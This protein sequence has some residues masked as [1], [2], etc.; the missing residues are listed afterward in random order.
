M[1]NGSFA[2][3]LQ[4]I[5]RDGNLTGADLA[6]WFDRPDPTVRGWISGDHELS[7]PPLD[8]AFVLA[9]LDKLERLLKQNKGLPVPRMAP[10]KRIEHL[11]VLKAAR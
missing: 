11:Q 9:Q 7:G 5:M 6:R 8:T 2:H 1:K 3:R 10:S 4:S